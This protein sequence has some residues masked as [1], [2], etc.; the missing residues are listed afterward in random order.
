MYNKLLE[1]WRDELKSDELTELPTD[2][3]Q[4]VAD[5]LK[6]ISEERR[7]LDK[8]TAKAS[9]L[10]KEE[11]NVKRILKELI[12]VRFKKLAKKAGKGEKKL[13]GL[14]FFEE[15][16]LSKLSSSLES[17][18]VYVKEM[19]QGRDVKARSAGRFIALRFLKEVPEI[20]GLDMKVYG[21]FKAE[22]VAALP[23]ENA[24]ILVKQGLAVEIEVS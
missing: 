1:I 13:Q 6:K 18:Q 16:T 3:V 23:A 8:K 2:F 17:Y 9:L 10:K 21:P 7:M 5:Y 19:L 20:V 12:R 14:L 15:E 24:K 11:Q 4:K 22:D